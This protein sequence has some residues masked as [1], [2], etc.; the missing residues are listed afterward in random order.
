MLIIGRI[1]GTA[2]SEHT[3]GSFG[4]ASF[5]CFT[6]ILSNSLLLDFVLAGLSI[7]RYLKNSFL[8]LLQKYQEFKRDITVIQSKVYIDHTLNYRG[9]GVIR[10]RG[11]CPKTHPD[12]S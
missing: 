9:V 8:R 2:R 10:T 6:A 5:A 3:I 12:N 11:N 4:E 7:L 1:E